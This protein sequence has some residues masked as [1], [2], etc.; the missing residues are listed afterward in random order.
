MKHQTEEIYSTLTGLGM[1]KLP[2]GLEHGKRGIGDDA[3]MEWR[4]PLV[5][6]VPEKM[7]RDILT[8]HALRWLDSLLEPVT[9]WWF[10]ENEYGKAGPKEGWAIRTLPKHQIIRKDYY[11]EDLLDA[12]VEAAKAIG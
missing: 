2:Y 11:G 8:M 12:I 3:Y 10:F 6:R 9:S 7:A 5:G 1:G 4:R